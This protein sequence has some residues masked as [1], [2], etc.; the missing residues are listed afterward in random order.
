MRTQKSIPVVDVVFCYVVYGVFVFVPG[1]DLCCNSHANICQRDAARMEPGN[2][3]E[4]IGTDFESAWGN[5]HV[6]RDFIREIKAQGFKSIRIPVTWNQRMS[7]APDYTIDPVFLNRVQEVVDWSLAGLYV[8]INVHD[9]WQWMRPSMA[10]QHDTVMAQFQAV[11]TQI[12]DRFKN[13][14]N[15]LMFESA[16]EPEYIGVDEAS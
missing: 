14:S 1:F 12:A 8:M 11:W 13:H 9:V 15:M 7:G 3:L 16:N 2:T 5:P 10:T 4:V 6:T